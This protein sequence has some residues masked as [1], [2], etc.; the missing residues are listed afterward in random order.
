MKTEQVELIHELGREAE[1][2]GEQWGNYFESALFMHGHICGGMPLGFRAALAALK[3]LDTE[4]ELN[5]GKL[6]FVETATGHAA[7][8]FADG[9]QLASGCTYGKGLM[10]R[11]EF[12]KWA[13]TLVDKAS[14][15]AVRIAVRPEVMQAAFHS[16]FIELRKQGTPP[17]EVPADVSRAL[18]D[19]L[20]N[21]TD[22]ELFK[23]SELF[24]YALPAA[25]KPT[26]ELITCNQCG[27][28]VAANKIRVKNGE[29]VCLPCSGYPA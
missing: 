12:G 22:E 20:L 2:F 7:G 6:V 4:R 23:V 24:E 28:V 26:F 19:N 25:P 14:H 9:A 16:P 17:T 15:K 11:T 29:T 13:I 8:C 21:K 3:A 1:K 18:V 27:E 10:E 5:M